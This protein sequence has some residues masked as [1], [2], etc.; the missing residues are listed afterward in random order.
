MEEEDTLMEE[1]LVL[2]VSLLVMAIIV[3]VVV[4]M[5]GDPRWHSNEDSLHWPWR[6]CTKGSPMPWMIVEGESQLKISK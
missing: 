5:E 1:L 6:H 3:E 2:E 4:V